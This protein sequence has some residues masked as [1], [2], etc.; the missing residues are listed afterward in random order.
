MLLPNSG[1]ANPRRTSSSTSPLIWTA[2]V[3]GVVGEHSDRTQPGWLDWPGRPGPGPAGTQFGEKGSG[4]AG[5]QFSP[6]GQEVP[7][8]VD[9][10]QFRIGGDPLRGQHARVF[11]LGFGQIV[12]GLTSTDHQVGVLGEEAEVGDGVDQ[13]PVVPG[14]VQAGLGEDVV[15]LERRQMAEHLRLQIQ[16]AA[17]VA[18]A[19]HPG[20][21]VQQR[22]EPGARGGSVEVVWCD[23]QTPAPPPLQAGDQPVDAGPLH[24]LVVLGEHGFGGAGEPAP[25]GCVYVPEQHPVPLR[26]IDEPAAALVQQQGDDRK[27]VPGHQHPVVVKAKP[28]GQ[29]VEERA[30]VAGR[31]VQRG[32]EVGGGH[33]VQRGEPRPAGRHRCSVAE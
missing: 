16:V 30:D 31:T 28:A 2:R 5:Q 29:R 22:V 12:G 20:E 23:V 11:R 7:V 14:L 10:P 15:H 25:Q 8:A 17:Q 27:G 19:P 24:G 32:G 9:L 3:P 6:G 26:R 13:T 33:P 1:L 21:Q 4:G 18:G